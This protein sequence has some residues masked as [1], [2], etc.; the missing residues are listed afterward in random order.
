ME[1]PTEVA[2]PLN[3]TQTKKCLG[4][5]LKV[6]SLSTLPLYKERKVVKKH[7]HEIGKLCGL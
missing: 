3:K 1:W 6:T 4:A 7:D 5:E 2:M